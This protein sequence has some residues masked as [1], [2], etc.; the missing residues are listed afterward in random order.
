MAL[1]SYNVGDLAEVVVM[2]YDPDTIQLGLNVYHAKCTSKTGGSVT[3]QDIADRV[4]N[5]V[6]AMY[7]DILADDSNYYGVTS[8]NLDA[9]PVPSP[10]FAVTNTGAGTY[11][12]ITGP[13]QCAGFAKFRTG[14]SGRTGRGRK[15]YPFL[16]QDAFDADNQVQAAYRN[17]ADL[18]TQYF[19]T[20]LVIIGAGTANFTWGGW[21]RVTDDF[22]PWTGAVT[23]FFIATQRRRGAFGRTNFLPVP[24]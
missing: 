4:D 14:V 13:D 11:G 12:G 1:P 15:Y 16:P 8:K 3:D 18:I 22:L 21:N 7:K 6:F 2:C 20:D 19:V 5:D 9:V 10:A 24:S 23:S 17:N